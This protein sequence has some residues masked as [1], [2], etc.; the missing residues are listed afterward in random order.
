[1]VLVQKI[2]PTHEMLPKMWVNIK[3]SV[4]HTDKNN[5]LHKSRSQPSIAAFPLQL[6]PHRSIQVDSSVLEGPAQIA[7]GQ[8]QYQTSS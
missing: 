4:C 3:E 6:F 1:M 7:P 5:Y 2:W 8:I